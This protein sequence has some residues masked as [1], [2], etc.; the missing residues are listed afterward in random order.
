VNE[1]RDGMSILDF[2]YLV[3]VPEGVKRFSEHHELGLF[4]HDEHLAAFRDSGLEASF[5]PPGVISRGF[6][7]GIK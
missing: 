1:L 2:H 5:D 7:L 3:C 4:T 6:Y